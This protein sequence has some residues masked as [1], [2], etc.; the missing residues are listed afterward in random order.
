MSACLKAE[1]SA[2]AGAYGARFGGW[3]KKN[4]TSAGIK[5]SPAYITA[6]RLRLDTPKR[7]CFNF[8]GIDYDHSGTPALVTV[9][10]RHFGT[11]ALVIVATGV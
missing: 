6:P 4:P 10:L 2:P 3:V 9:V 5:H 1:I 11:P 7:L 8:L